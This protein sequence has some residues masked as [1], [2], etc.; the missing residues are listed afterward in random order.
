MMVKSKIDDCSDGWS[1]EYDSLPL[2]AR[3]KMLLSRKQASD[4]VFLKE[5]VD[6][7]QCE[8]TK[9]S[10]DGEENGCFSSE[11]ENVLPGHTRNESF[12][13]AKMLDSPSFQAS[14]CSLN[15]PSSPSSSGLCVVS[16]GD[17]SYDGNRTTSSISSSAFLFNDRSPVS[18]TA[19]SA[20]Q[21]PV[22]T[23]IPSKANEYG[24]VAL[25]ISLKSSISSSSASKQGTKVKGEISVD[26]DD[27][28]ENIVLRE[29]RKMLLSRL[30]IKSQ[31]PCIQACSAVMPKLCLLSVDAVQQCLLTITEDTGEQSIA[32]NLHSEDKD[33]DLCFASDTSKSAVTGTSGAINQS[34]ALSSDE[35]HSAKPVES[36]S[37]IKLYDTERIP[38]SKGLPSHI[39]VKVEPLLSN[40]CDDGGNYVKENFTSD[41]IPVKG[42]LRVDDAG[43]EGDSDYL[44]LKER[45]ILSPTIKC[46]FNHQNKTVLSTGKRGV[47]LLNSSRPSIADS[48]DY[49]PSTSTEHKPSDRKEKGTNNSKSV[50]SFPPAI[51]VKIE[52]VLS[53][54]IF[55]EQKTFRGKSLSR[56]LLKTEA[57]AS[58]EL[59]EDELDHMSLFDRLMLLSTDPSPSSIVSKN[60][61]RAS[62][63]ASSNLGSSRG[64]LESVESITVTRPWKR[65][66]TATNSAETA[67]EEDVPGLLK[68]LIDKGV[69]LEDIKLYG[70]PESY[71]AID[72]TF[73]EDSF[74][75]LE[76]VLWKIFSPREPLLKV[77]SLCGSKETKITYC[78]GCLFSLV[79]QARCLRSKNWPAEWGWSRDLQ[80]FI[81][82]FQR[83]NRIVMERPEY[84]F[85]TYFF[86]MLDSVSVGWQI[87][88][89]VTS[90]KLSGCGRISLLEN[91]ALLVGEDLSEGEARVLSQYGWVPNTGL[92]TMLNYCGRVIHDTNKERDGNE[93]RQKIG[94]ML[95][96][97]YNGGSLVPRFLVKKPEENE[98]KPSPE[99]KL[100]IDPDWALL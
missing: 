72:E 29:R 39:Q 71:D 48:N 17:E 91:R 26:F 21:Q 73:C 35:L 52:P 78:L 63:I 23:Y 38:R 36:T 86:E 32:G 64:V 77:T 83:H 5:T 100:E 46:R 88:R 99:I 80:A 62:K 2:S 95:V 85:A 10:M 13:D 8:L 55:H 87:R 27:D 11:E 40:E 68:V 43:A 47:D 60:L 37:D 90:M 65:K 97:G 19:V 7:G 31:K 54:E 42:D 59:S 84:G 58:L 93:W 96:D 92:A 12:F 41:V 67:L 22:V 79:E 89:L 49:G 94:K 34:S 70:E 44:P 1:G 51:S 9:S 53:S 74:T 61:N 3:L 56:I 6:C 16:H 24:D 33:H 98:S 75:E 69:S 81:F 18:D 28:L 57:T 30:L 45:P 14:D 66:R 4:S 50:S 76:A 20:L 82:V 15:Y 25:A